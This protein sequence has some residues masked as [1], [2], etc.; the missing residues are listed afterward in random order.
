MSLKVAQRIKYL[1]VNIIGLISWKLQNANE[2]KRR[3]K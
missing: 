1:G 3:P 2:R